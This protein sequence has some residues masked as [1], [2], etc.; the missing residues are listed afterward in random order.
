MAKIL[1][2]VELI[3]VTRRLSDKLDPAY[4][5]R[6]S[7][8]VT[9]IRSALTELGEIAA[10][11]LRCESTSCDTEIEGCPAP[12]C[13]LMGFTVSMFPKTHD[14]EIPQELRDIDR[15]SDWEP[16]H[17]RKFNPEIFRQKPQDHRA[18]K[19]AA[20]CQ[21]TGRPEA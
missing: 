6:S 16:I 20:H 11:H 4:Q 3:L 14:E 1:T 10:A 19:E 5:K 9:T 7:D 18:A 8:L 15:E 12:D 17:S 21:K 2:P 13:G